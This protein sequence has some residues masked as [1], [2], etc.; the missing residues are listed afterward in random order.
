MKKES[1]LPDELHARRILFL[2]KEIKEPCL[3]QFFRVFSCC[4]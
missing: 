1:F 3:E 2:G 4:Y